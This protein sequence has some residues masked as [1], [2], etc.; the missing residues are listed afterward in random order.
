[1]TLEIVL[2]L[3]RADPTVGVALAGDGSMVCIDV[4]KFASIVSSM[5]AIGS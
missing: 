5:I 1:L 3:V 4:D 2:L